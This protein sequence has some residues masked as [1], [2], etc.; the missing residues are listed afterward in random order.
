M[1]SQPILDKDG[2]EIRATR[3]YSEAVG[4][5]LLET[6]EN[7]AIYPITGDEMYVRAKVVSTKVKETPFQEGDHEMA[8]TQ[9][10]RIP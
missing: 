8:W 7:P 5:V 10:L 9:P 2:K 6:T 4:K 1:A 3:Q